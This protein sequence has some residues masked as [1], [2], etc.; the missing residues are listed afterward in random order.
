VPTACGIAYDQGGE[1]P[2]LLLLHGLGSRRRFWA[3][4]RGRLER[5][6]AVTAVD[7]PG[8]GA[9]PLLPEG[10][11]SV[12]ALAE[13]VVRLLDVLG[14]EHPHVAGHS[15]GGWVALEVARLGRAASVTA[16]APAGFW[17]EPERLYAKALLATSAR[18]ARAADPLLPAIFATARGRRLT[19]GR[20]IAH[21]ERLSPAEAVDDTRA[22]ARSPGFDATLAAI[23]GGERRFARGEEIR[24]PVSIAWGGRDSLLFPVQGL[25]AVAEIP[26][27]RLTLMPDAGHAPNHD[28]P[29]GLLRAVLSGSSVSRHVAASAGMA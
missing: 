25:R 10:T 7:M 23:A 5:E 16:V 9:S 2:P 18:L 15:L 13:A 17:S 14:I 12:R 19:M 28:D 3:P 27:A 4:V 21:P 26:G 11:P 29:E 8:F 24:C 6:R 1:G 20:L 22:L